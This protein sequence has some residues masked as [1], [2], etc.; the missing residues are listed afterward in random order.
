MIKNKAQKSIGRSKNKGVER[1]DYEGRNEGAVE[2]KKSMKM[3]IRISSNDA[4]KESKTCR[5]PTAVRCTV[6]HL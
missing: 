3:I 1:E 5:A 2:Y 6:A 4:D